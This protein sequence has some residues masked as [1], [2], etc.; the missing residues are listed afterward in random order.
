MYI[1]AFK[2]D[3]ENVLGA[4]GQKELEEAVHKLYR[5]YIKGEEGGEIRVRGDVHRCAYTVVRVSSE[6]ARIEKSTTRPRR[7][8]RR[9]P[10]HWPTA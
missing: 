4:F 9:S 6:Q 5:K 8:V 3:L 2:R 10:L 1:S 7:T